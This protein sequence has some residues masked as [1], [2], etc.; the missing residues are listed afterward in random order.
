MLVLVG[1]TLVV[2]LEVALVL[3]C[4]LVEAAD[5]RVRVENAGEH[6]ADTA[7]MAASEAT[8]ANSANV[9]RPE[10]KCAYRHQNEIAGHDD[11][12]GSVIGPDKSPA[13]AHLPAC[14]ICATEV[15]LVSIQSL[16]VIQINLLFLL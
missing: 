10:P 7:N 15:Q 8:I 4:R 3:H 5:A 14:L 6:E 11:R 13:S 12:P 16:Q 1:H 9:P 2:P